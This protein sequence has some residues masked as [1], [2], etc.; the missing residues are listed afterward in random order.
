MKTLVL[1][2]LA[3]VVIL[4]FGIGTVSAQADKCFEKGG[5]WDAQQQ[6]CVIQTG[7]EIDIHY[8]LEITQY[9][10]VEQ[11]VDPFLNGL[12]SKYISDFAALGPDVWTPGPW[13]L[14]ID[15][16]IFQFS[17]TML[18]LKFTISDYTGGAHGNMYF[19]TYLFD[20]AQNRVLTLSDLFQ[21]GADPLAT[22]APIVQQD[23]A[24]QMGD[25][26]DTQWI[27]EGTSSL[28]AYV[29]FV[30]TPDSL[31]FFFPPYQVAAYA[32]GPQ[33]VQI[34]LSQISGILAPPFNR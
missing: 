15:Y 34:P 28:D 2:L 27:Q 9:P 22:L 8:P 7:I 4:V 6:K 1:G 25:F 30:V 12:R 16:E 13:G 10:F 20:L 11:T 33:T 18:S 23:L 14:H 21:P 19:Q 5:N 26:A 31:I 17:P 29:N 32:A 3:V 24:A